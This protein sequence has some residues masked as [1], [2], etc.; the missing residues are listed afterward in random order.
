MD[1]SEHVREN[2]VA[3]EWWAPVNES[4]SEVSGNTP[5]IDDIPPPPHHPQY[6]S[7]PYLL[8][9]HA[10][11]PHHPHHHVTHSPIQPIP[12]QNQRRKPSP[13][14]QQARLYQNAL[15]LT[16]SLAPILGP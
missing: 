10:A 7:S 12:G 15:A 9:P 16:P 11:I 13:E 3:R 14:K 6:S 1:W 4:E 5:A 2:A 8:P